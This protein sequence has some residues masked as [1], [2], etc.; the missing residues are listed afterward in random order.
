MILVLKASIWEYI[1]F[2]NRRILHLILISI[3]CRQAGYLV[4][5]TTSLPKIL[6]FKVWRNKCKGNIW[7]MSLWSCIT[8]V[9]PFCPLTSSVACW[10]DRKPQAW[11]LQSTSA[12]KFQILG[13]PLLS[14]RDKHFPRALPFLWGAD[15][16]V[17]DSLPEWS[18]MVTTVPVLGSWP[19]LSSSL[20]IFKDTLSL[21]FPLHSTITVATSSS[22]T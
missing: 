17:R 5:A 12:W 18:Q 19:S 20:F 6:H 14:M 16:W 13:P 22:R 15:K 11:T 9:G 7:R 1:L 4:S 10:K 21:F 2:F 3:S 8:K